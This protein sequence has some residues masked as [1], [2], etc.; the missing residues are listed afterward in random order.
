M[1]RNER[2]ARALNVLDAI[3]FAVAARLGFKNPAEVSDVLLPSYNAK[4]DNTVR[5]YC[6]SDVAGAVGAC[7]PV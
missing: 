2:I 6:A 5:L 3:E 7:A 4:V 1:H